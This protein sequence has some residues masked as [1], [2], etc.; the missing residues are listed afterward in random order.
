MS[1]KI[2]VVNATSDKC[3]PSTCSLIHEVEENIW[4]LVMSI[5]YERSYSGKLKADLPDKEF[6]D[7][8][9]LIRHI[10]ACNRV[11]VHVSTHPVTL[12]VLCPTIHAVRDLLFTVEKGAM[13]HI[14]QSVL[15]TDRFKE[16]FKLK[17]LQLS[18]T[19]DKNECLF[20]VR[21][22]VAIGE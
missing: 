12:V 4:S 20:C 9:Q 3:S 14:C 15:A 16:R 18:V 2:N 8:L 21:Q 13:S 19:T 22:L 5:L 17:T 10:S 6:G 7:I 11:I 1:L